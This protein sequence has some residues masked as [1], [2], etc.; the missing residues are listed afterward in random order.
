MRPRLPGTGIGTGT[1]MPF[2]EGVGLALREG[3]CMEE[4]WLCECECECE[5]GW[6]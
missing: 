3:C 5:C 2:V 4:M 6:F 1:G